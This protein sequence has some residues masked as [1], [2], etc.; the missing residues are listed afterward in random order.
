MVIHVHGSVLGSWQ[1]LPLGA[2]ALQLSALPI[3]HEHA[4][5]FGNGLVSGEWLSWAG[6]G[7]DGLGWAG[8]G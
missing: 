7:W 2:V 5:A 1:F 3:F 8:L 4:G 6:P